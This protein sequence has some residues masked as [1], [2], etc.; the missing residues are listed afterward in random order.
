MYLKVIFIFSAFLAKIICTGS[1]A[2]AIN[3]PTSADASNIEEIRPPSPFPTIPDVTVAPEILTETERDLKISRPVSP[4]PP[5]QQD[6]KDT[7]PKPEP[8]TERPVSPFPRIPDITMDTDLVETDVGKFKEGLTLESTMLPNLPFPAIPNI[9]LNP[10]IIEKDIVVLRTSPVPLEHTESKEEEQTQEEE[11][12]GEQNENK[13]DI[14]FPTIPDFSS[15]PD[16][17]QNLPKPFCLTQPTRK[18]APVSLTGKKYV[19]EKPAVKPQSQTVAPEF[20]FSIGDTEWKVI[21]RSHNSATPIRTI[22]SEMFESQGHFNASGTCSPFPVYIPGTTIEMS[23]TERK[24]VIREE[25]IKKYI[26]DTQKAIEVQKQVTEREIAKEDHMKLSEKV[27]KQVEKQCQVQYSQLEDSSEVKQMLVRM[28]QVQSGLNLEGDSEELDKI[29]SEMTKKEEC[30]ESCQVQASKDSEIQQV[31]EIEAVLKPQNESVIQVNQA[32]TNEQQIKSNGQAK[33]FTESHQEDAMKI[34]KA[35]ES[36]NQE[37][38][39]FGKCSVRSEF[40]LSP[41]NQLL[42]D[43]GMSIEE[44]INEK[45]KFQRSDSLTKLRQ[46]P[47]EEIEIEKPQCQKPP[48]TVVGARPLFGQLDINAEIKKALVGKKSIHGKHTNYHIQ[49]SD[50]EPKI[51]IEKS[52]IK[53]HHDANKDSK[54][55]SE[56][57]TN[58]K[59][60][61]TT[62]AK[63]EDEEI[64]KIYYQRERELEMDLQ[65]VQEEL[66][67]PDGTVIP[68]SKNK[69]KVSYVENAQYFEPNSYSYANTNKLSDEELLKKSER[70]LYSK[71]SQKLNQPETFQ[72]RAARNLNH[73]DG[74]AEQSGFFEKV[75]HNEVDE[76]QYRKLPVKYLIKNFEQNS[77]PPI[78]YKQIK[79]VSNILP[80]NSDY[81]VNNTKEEQFLRQ[82]EEDF[83]NLYYVANTAV[84]AKQF[85]PV[86][87]K[88]QGFKQSENSSFCKYSAEAFQ[89]Q[90]ETKNQMFQIERAQKAQI[91]SQS[92]DDQE[93]QY[94]TSLAQSFERSQMMQSQNLHS[95]F[96]NNI[97]SSSLEIT[98]A[99]LILEG[100]I[101]V[102]LNF[103]DVSLLSFL[104]VCNRLFHCD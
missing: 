54:V 89:T 69:P 93:L 51:K 73:V 46:R 71:A 4:F 44:S 100:K 47:F 27:K 38:K 24:E 1:V 97:E 92:V 35:S 36:E 48:Q 40:E 29:D 13:T 7:K 41:S 49:T 28:K 25:D 26:E 94:E 6:Q 45:P 87:S 37:C 68:L 52:E 56:L 70:Y 33:L 102:G 64:D 34:Q 76:E 85:Y 57:K 62:I 84:E 32:L 21:E 101:F 74:L 98:P 58:E 103:C 31:T 95:A 16:P 22:Q 23:G 20:N 43:Q 30:Y 9:S 3:A 83:E 17:F 91:L 19:L 61:I 79:D 65:M 75:E 86:T 53:T 12:V 66:V 82:A 99:R 5:S 90:D 104:I 63:T 59:A 42:K 14:P 2:L 50:K 10:D 80:S 67:M 18:Y 39:E 78:R 8:E 11:V 96:S 77:M 88:S 72:F 55:S 81:Q 60:E 15:R